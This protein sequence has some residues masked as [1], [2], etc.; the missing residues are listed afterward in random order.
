MKP[1]IDPEEQAINQARDEAVKNIQ[2]YCA[3][4]IRR[5]QVKAKKI[6]TIRIK[7]CLN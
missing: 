3:E 4:S 7:C 5:D 2:A 1:R 6:K